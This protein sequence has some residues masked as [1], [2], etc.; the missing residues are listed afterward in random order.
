MLTRTMSKLFHMRSYATLL[1]GLLLTLT[2]DAQPSGIVSGQVLEA[3]GGPAAGAKVT[4]SAEPERAKTSSG[5]WSRVVIADDRGRFVIFGVPF[6]ER[7]YAVAHS[8]NGLA[9]GW[10]APCIRACQRP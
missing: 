1:F 7:Y 8:P 6:H 3:E 9:W 10:L 5:P 4:I 2:T